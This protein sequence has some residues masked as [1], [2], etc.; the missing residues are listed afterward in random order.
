MIDVGGT[1]ACVLF[2]FGNSFYNSMWLVANDII[3]GVAIGSY[4]MGNRYVVSNTVHVILKVRR[5]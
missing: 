3:I 2:S 5:I 4:L 1:K